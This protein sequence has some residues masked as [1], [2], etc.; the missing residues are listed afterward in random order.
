MKL[1]GFG[2]GNGWGTGL[3]IGAAAILLAPIAIGL[4]AGLMKPVAKGALKGGMVM[5][6][7][8]KKVAADARQSFETLKSEAKAEMSQE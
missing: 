6:N 8:G 2:L 3:L 4:A 5:Y 1:A 7:R